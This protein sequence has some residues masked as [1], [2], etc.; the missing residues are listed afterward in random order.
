MTPLPPIENRPQKGLK[1]WL[2]KHL[3]VAVLGLIVTALTL[4]LTLVFGLPPF[5]KSV[6]ETWGEPTLNIERSTPLTLRYDPKKNTLTFAFSFGLENAGSKSEAVEQCSAYL[7]T[8][9]DDNRRWQFSDPDFVLRTD[10]NKEGKKFV[11]P[12]NVTQSMQCEITS[13]VTS[14]RIAALLG[15]Q[16]R[17]EFVLTI[18]G[19]K[20]RPY[21]TKYGFDFSRLTW[22]ALVNPPFHVRFVGSNDQ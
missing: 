17:R 19:R 2:K 9:G 1:D 12:R 11:I 15:N 22:D 6:Q 4:V 18:T 8:P 21:V 13:D 3:S 5:C 20:G 7:D 10:D 16:T 14:D